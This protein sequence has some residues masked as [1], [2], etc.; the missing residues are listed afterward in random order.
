MSVARAPRLR[1]AGARPRLAVLSVL[2]LAAVPTAAAARR[3]EADCE[4]LFLDERVR[5]G[6][7]APLAL[8]TAG[9]CGADAHL[10]IHREFLPALA[11]VLE[12]AKQCN[13]EEV[14]RGGIRSTP[15]R[16]SR[17]SHRVA[18]RSWW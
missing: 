17:S 3:R 1:P 18:A 14:S 6:S 7:L 11:A 15:L 4:V 5:D 2:L 10:A 8:C 16:P 13:L 9:K 12:A